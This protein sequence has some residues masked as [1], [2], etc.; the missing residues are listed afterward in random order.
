MRDSKSIYSRYFTY[1][2]PITKIPIVK[3]YGSAIFTI[4]ITAIF[5]I[6]AIKPTVETIIV[7]QKKLADSNQILEKITKKSENLSL[8]KQNY[9]QMDTN[10]KTKIQ[11]GIPDHPEFKSITDAL[12]QAAERNDASIS[13]L[14]IAPLEITSKIPNQVASL[15]EISFIFNTTGEYQK[16]ILLLQDLKRSDRLISIDSMSLSTLS[17][18]KGIIMSISGKAYY[19]K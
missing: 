15:S 7:L 8:G 14:Q 1:I 12:E 13:A 16:L 2:K 9:D 5:I 4:L 11:A 3:N 18:E 17:E 6:F 10:I 19:L